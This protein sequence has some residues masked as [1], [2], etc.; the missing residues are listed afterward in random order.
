MQS[1]FQGLKITQEPRQ[2][3][4]EERMLLSSAVLSSTLRTNSPTSLLV[5]YESGDDA[6]FCTLVPGARETLNFS[7]VVSPGER[8]SLRSSNENDL[9]I[10][11]TRSGMDAGDFEVSASPSSL[12]I[13]KLAS[14]DKAHLGGAVTY[15]L[16]TATEGRK[17]ERISI[18]AVINGIESTIA[19]LIPGKIDTVE[20]ALETFE[21]EE[22]EVFLVGKGKVH[23]LGYVDAEDALEEETEGDCEE[24]YDYDEDSSECGSEDGEGDGESISGDHLLDLIDRDAKM[25]KAQVGEGAK[26]NRENREAAKKPKKEKGA[27]GMHIVDILKSKSA[28]VAKKGDKV[29]VRYIASLEGGK[30]VDRSAKKGTTFSL[31]K[32]EVIRGMERGIEGM[33]VGSKRK[34]VIPPSLGYG[35]SKVG[36]VPANSTLVLQV[37][38]LEVLQGKK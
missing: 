32:D 10:N 36:A 23:M 11:C 6:V 18:C 7:L 21:G 12:R 13:V 4:V 19:N 35:S 14:G 24:T 9:F 29:R 2:I 22:I 16:A 28:Q 30:E 31:G 3:A 5:S 17:G 33:S 27:D 15:S 8:F 20:L 25:A 38:L 1:S 26:E 34:L 37:E